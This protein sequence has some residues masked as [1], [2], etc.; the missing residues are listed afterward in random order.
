MKAGIIGCGDFLRWQLDA[1]QASRRVDVVS[2]YDPDRSRAEKYAEKLG[3]RVVESA[4]AIFSDQSIGLVILFV[5]PWVR[6]GYVE[7][8][9]SAGKHILTTKPLAPNVEEATRIRELVDGSAGLRCGVIYRR[10]GDAM[11]D[12]LKGV[13]DEGGYGKLALFKL[14][15][16]HHYPQWN[17][18][19]LD[20]EKNGGPFMDA[21][22]HNLNISRY[23]MGRP[24]EKVEFLSMR[25]AHPELSCADT[26]RMTVWFKEGGL[27]DLFITWAADMAVY[28]TEGNDR[29]HIEQFFMIT[30]TGWLVRP[31]TTAVGQRCVQASRL[32]EQKEI[33]L[34]ESQVAFYDLFVD[35]VETGDSN[36]GTLPTVDDAYLDIEL[37]VKS[38]RDGKAAVS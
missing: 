19:A 27:A 13:F 31:G 33:P 22:I 2:L 34:D 10:T 32:G 12:T 30:D 1:I 25:L 24:I 4:D 20:P 26:E 38:A 3:G 8:A 15:W 14:D 28:G 11:F 37:I 29:E 6:L 17:D 36:P 35:C 18:W 23:L 16:L 21:N 9:V 5:P 7:N